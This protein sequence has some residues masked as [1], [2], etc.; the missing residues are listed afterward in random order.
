M[1]AI[2]VTIGDEILLGQ[3]LDTNSRYAASALARLGIETVKMLSVSDKPQEIRAAA[4]AA[5]QQADLV[6]FTGGLGPTKDDLTKK[7]LADYFGTGLV[8]NE[9]AY[10]WVKEFV[11]HYPNGHMNE[12]NKNQALL[13]E[14]CTLLRNRKGTASGMWFERAGKV[15][16][17]L[18]GVPFEAEYLI[19]EEVLPRL[20]KRLAGDLLK[21]KMLTV[22]DVPESDLAMSLRAF[23]D[24]LPEGVALAYL[25]S[26]GF[27]RL[28]LTAKGTAV[29][30]LDACWNALTGALQGKRFTPAE[31]GAPEDV[32]AREIAALGVTVATAE[33]CTGGNV[34]HLITSVAGASRYFS[35]GVVSYANEVKMRVLGVRAEDLQQY[36]AV[37]EQVAIAMAEGCR[38]VCGSDLALSIT[39]VAGPDKDDRDN[40]VGTVYMALSAQ[41]G[42]VC[43]LVDLTRGR[44]RGH[45]RHLAATH[46]FDMIRRKLLDLPM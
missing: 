42:T 27:V 37:S 4:D 39:G 19:K 33:S 18:P 21:Y 28:R 15:L 6:I 31:S 3:I 35:G 8:F 44:G 46:A 36:G 9:D 17:S 22:Y 40:P 2:I 13:P 34:A 43:R 30:K 32:F 45:I 26:P 20:E 11:S 24:G 10:G 41:D 16:V 29:Q 23:E 12:Y 7:T 25:P 14:K 1:K 38:R 5:L